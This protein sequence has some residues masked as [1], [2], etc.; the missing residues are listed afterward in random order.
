MLSK[1]AFC[2][3]CI[4]KET[5]QNSLRPLID[6]KHKYEQK[7]LELELMDQ[8]F[9]KIITALAKNHILYTL[10]HL[11][12]IEDEFYLEDAVRHLQFSMKYVDE[13]S[14]GERKGSHGNP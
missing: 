6:I 10:E 4:D 14:S 1:E 13:D 2:D 11:T 12:E 7:T 8:V 9:G 3:D 5:A